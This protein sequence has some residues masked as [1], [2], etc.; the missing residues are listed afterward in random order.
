MQK[1]MNNACLSKQ[2]AHWNKNVRIYHQVFVDEFQRP[3]NAIRR[4]QVGLTNEFNLVQHTLS[5][6]T[7]C[8]LNE[9]P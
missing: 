6:I 5:G 4:A 7:L 3:L 9:Q 1:K 2:L 8:N